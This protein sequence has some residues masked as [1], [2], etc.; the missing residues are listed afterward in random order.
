[1]LTGLCRPEE[2]AQCL[3]FGA[4]ISNL[5]GVPLETASICD[6]PGY[7]WGIVPMMAQAGVKYFAI[8]PNYS[9]RVGTIHL[10]DD[11]PFYWKSQSGKERRALLG[12]RQ[13]SSPGNLEENVLQQV[14]RLDRNGLSLRHLLHLLGRR[15]AGRWRG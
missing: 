10:W 11:K 8:G 15:L 9:D 12:G 4:R 2:F 6:V 7:T 5:T 3:A 14:D 13:L 1:M